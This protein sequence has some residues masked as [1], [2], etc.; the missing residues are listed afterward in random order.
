MLMVPNSPSTS[1]TSSRWSGEALSASISSAMLSS[2]SDSWRSIIA[3]LLLSES[4]NASPAERNRRRRAFIPAGLRGEFEEGD[5]D[6]ETDS[7]GRRG[8]HIV[9]VGLRD[10]SIQ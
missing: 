4:R 1:S 8:R 9:A 3:A 6:E 5:D 2:G 7:G 10:Q